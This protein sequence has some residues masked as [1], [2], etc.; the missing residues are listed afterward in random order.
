M[1]ATMGGLVPAIFAALA[2]VSTSTPAATSSVAPEWVPLAEPEPAEE[3]PFGDAF[4]DDVPLT[5]EE[6]A[7]IGTLTTD[8]TTTSTHAPPRFWLVPAPLPRPTLILPRAQIR[9]SISRSVA[10]MFEPHPTVVDT[11]RRFVPGDSAAIRGQSGHRVALYMDGVPLHHALTPSRETAGIFTIDPWMIGEAVLERPGSLVLS[12]RGTAGAIRLS[13]IEPRRAPGIEAEAELAARSA[14]RSTATH[15]AASLA[16]EAGAI[17]VAA[18]YNDYRPLHIATN[19]DD[20]ADLPGYQRAAINSRARLFGRDN[21]PVSLYGGFDFDR[22]LNVVRTDLDDD[23]PP[24]DRLNQRLLAFARAHFGGED[25]TGSVLVAR[26]SFLRRVSTPPARTTIDDEAVSYFTRGSVELRLL[27]ELTLRAGG[28]IDSSSATSQP[29]SASKSKLGSTMLADGYLAIDLASDRIWGSAQVALVHGSTDPVEGDEVRSTRA[30]SQGGLRV[31][32]AGPIGLRAGWTQ[33]LYV[34]TIQDLRDAV[35]PLGPE[36]S[37]SFD[38]GPSLYERNGWIE[39]LGFYTTVKNAIE[40][41]TLASRG[42][43]PI[44]DVRILGLELT[45]GWYLVE[46]L[47]VAGSITW[48]EG[49]N[50]GDDS[51]VV[52]FPSLTGRASVRY[53]LGVRNAYLEAHVRA[54]SDPIYVTSLKG[55][56]PPASLAGLAPTSFARFGVGGATDLGLGFRLQIM[57]ENVLD[58]P[59]R[60]PASLVPGAGVDL[61]AALSY[62]ID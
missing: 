19:N 61:R 2:S 12:P 42:L 40:P 27:P 56:A 25:L 20:E 37:V 4:D 52:T 18:G 35:L 59:H 13:A 7:L 50:A 38:F 55:A 32:V 49:R 14:D 26:Q 30:L 58:T 44:G 47:R 16:E 6:L 33:G 46:R 45:G 24:I 39:L 21:D 8:T 31:S 51:P 1:G 23:D 28:V 53:D 3:T 10:E 57:L 41:L 9:E 15:V 22:V 17:R 29:T 34:P 48:S 60:A 36:T 11:A 5:P 43:I 62:A 54:S